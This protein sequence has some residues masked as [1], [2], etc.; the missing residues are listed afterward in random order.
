M[1]DM[2]RKPRRILLVGGVIGLAAAAAIVA[3]A[4][5]QSGGEP[6]GFALAPGD[7]ALVAEGS[8]LY[9]LH[10]A[11]CHGADLEGE[12]AWR[13]RKAGG[14]LPAPPHDESG[15][16]WHHTDR[17]LFALTKYGPAALVGQGYESDMPAF[18]GVL[19]DREIAAVLSYIKSRWPAEVRRRH[20]EVN[21]RAR[22]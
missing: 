22:E 10:C 12:P 1:P 7:K 19:S 21:A 2:R 16:T 4:V 9:E 20:D 18:E 13:Q 14:R 3:V 6:S 15:H 8:R 5:W 17:Q 11:S